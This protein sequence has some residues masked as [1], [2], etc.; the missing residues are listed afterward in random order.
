MRKLLPPDDTQAEIAREVNAGLEQGLRLTFYRVHADDIPPLSY[1]M[2]W[3]YGTA[4]RVREQPD[5]FFDVDRIAKDIRTW[6]LKVE[7]R[8][9]RYTTVPY[10]EQE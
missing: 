3:Q 5:A 1:G 9:E 8:R 7:Q 2:I 6:R 10:E 4:R